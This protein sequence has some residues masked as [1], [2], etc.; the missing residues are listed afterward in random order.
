[1]YNNEDPGFLYLHWHCQCSSETGYHRWVRFFLKISE[2]ERSF[3]NVNHAH[4]ITMPQHGSVD[5]SRSDV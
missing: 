4:L 1:M 5:G 2:R 3:L